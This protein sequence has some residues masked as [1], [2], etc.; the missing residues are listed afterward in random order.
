MWLKRTNPG[1]AASLREG[2]DETLTVIRLVKSLQS[3]VRAEPTGTQ[4][5]VA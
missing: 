2:L 3:I 1:P 5:D 4:R